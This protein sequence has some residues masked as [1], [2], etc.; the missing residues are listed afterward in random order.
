[1][2]SPVSTG[3]GDRVQVWLPEAALFQYVTNQPGRFSFLLFMGWQNGYE[4]KG[5]DALWMSVKAGM[6]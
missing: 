3:M 5:G 2:L 6:V 4:P 1:M